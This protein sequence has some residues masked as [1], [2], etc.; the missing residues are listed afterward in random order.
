V[1]VFTIDYETVCSA[2]MHLHRIALWIGDRGSSND[3]AS[4]EG[5]ALER[6]FQ[7]L[8]NQIDHHIPSC[9]AVVGDE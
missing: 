9:I 5:G 6:T 2:C 3:I 1:A 8:R 7:P 4:I